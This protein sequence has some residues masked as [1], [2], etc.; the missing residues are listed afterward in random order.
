MTK[1]H[2]ILLAMRLAAPLLLAV[3]CAE[4]QTRWFRGNT[5]THTNLSD[6]DSAP[7]VVA[8]WYKNHGGVKIF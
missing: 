1:K 8:R 6:G 3:T 4:A 2:S 7:E 5:H